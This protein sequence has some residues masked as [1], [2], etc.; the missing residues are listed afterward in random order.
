MDRLQATELRDPEPGVG[1][2]IEQPGR[3]L[4]VA[5]LG[6]EMHRLHRVALIGVQTLVPLAPVLDRV[7]RRVG[8]RAA[9]QVDCDLVQGDGEETR[10]VVDALA[11]P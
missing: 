4:E 3:A 10:F 6:V 2:R 5:L 1:R 8:A 11:G 9:V 7:G